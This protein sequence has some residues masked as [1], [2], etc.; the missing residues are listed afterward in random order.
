MKE[1]GRLTKI[2]LCLQNALLKRF[3]TIPANFTATH[4]RID[5]LMDHMGRGRVTRAEYDRCVPPF[6]AAWALETVARKVSALI[7]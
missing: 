5:A 3:R 7:P 6:E 2:P 1:G 4:Q